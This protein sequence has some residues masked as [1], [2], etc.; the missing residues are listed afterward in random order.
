[1]HLQVLAKSLE[2]PPFGFPPTL[3]KNVNPARS[4]RHVSLIKVRVVSFVTFRVLRAAPVHEATSLIEKRGCSRGQP[5]DMHAHSEPPVC[6]P[7]DSHVYSRE[8]V[9]PPEKR[10]EKQSEGRPEQPAEHT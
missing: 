4:R 5:M 9:L 2:W 6:R 7:M 1:M 8:C 3:A 10:T